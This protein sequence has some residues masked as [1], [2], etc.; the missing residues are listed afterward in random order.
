MRRSRLWIVVFVG[1][2]LPACFRSASVPEAA[3]EPTPVAR[4]D[5][6]PETAHEPVPA[7][8]QPSIP[9]A[10]VA[11]RLSAHQSTEPPLLP[12]APT[13]EGWSGVALRLEFFYPERRRI[14]LG[15]G[16][17]IRDRAKEDY[18]VTCVHLIDEKEWKHRYSV[19]M[20]TMNGS[21]TIQSL[22][23]T[24]HVGNAVD[25]K[26]LG[27]DGRPDLTRDLVI[28]SVAGS[29]TRPLPLAPADP[30]VGEWLWAVGLEA[31]HPPANEKLFP[32]RVV[33]VTRGGFTVEQHV[34]FD[35]RGFS[36]GPVV[37]AR[38]QVAGNVL[39]GGMKRISG[40]TVTTIRSC[41]RANGIP[42]D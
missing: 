41:L 20:R 10:P 15:T 34:A 12:P 17:V 4:V 35:P 23:S 39:T 38:G 8:S 33:E 31:R 3:S 26:H 7:P 2:V 22:G 21:K 5:P 24:L 14:F 40:A 19:R 32:C 42:A 6:V 37:N 1:V 9:R 36:G 16:F 29:W 18:L 30:A 28:R 13:V 11:T 25:V 27:P